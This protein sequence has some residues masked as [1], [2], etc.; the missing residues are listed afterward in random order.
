MDR[1]NEIKKRYYYITGIL[2]LL[3][4][5]IMLLPHRNNTKEISPEDLL[6]AISTNDRFYNPD[7]VARL[8]ISGDPSIQLIDVRAPEEF[9]AFSLPKS[10]NIPLEKLLEKDSI[11]E[12]IW[13]GTLDQD[14]KKNI[15]YSNGTVYA[16]QAWMLT[17][18]MDFKNNY[19]MKGGLNSFFENIMQAKR[20][21][22]SASESEQNLY[23][24]RRAAAMYFGGGSSL[25]SASSDTKPADNAPV[26]K[27]KKEGSSGGC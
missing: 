2:F 23:N 1:R 20:P 17:R 3:G 24:F 10:I 11:G 15:F 9:A 7:D 5:I 6:L 21:L 4:L 14:V 13:E 25:P 18:R 22:V 26:K 8:I 27:K 19:V 12:Y 16:N